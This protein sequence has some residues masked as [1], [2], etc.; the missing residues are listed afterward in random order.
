MTMQEA[1]TLFL[2]E[3]GK[4]ENIGSRE[5]AR[6][7]FFRGVVAGA[8]EA[9]GTLMKMFPVPNLPVES[10]EDFGPIVKKSIL[11]SIHTIAKIHN[12]LEQETF[13]E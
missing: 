13:Y 9:R 11:E 1:E 7:W 6:K 12:K 3:I 4:E 8:R 2:E 10:G 5:E